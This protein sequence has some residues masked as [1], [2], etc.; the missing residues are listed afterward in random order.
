MLGK[1]RGTVRKGIAAGLRAT[2]KDLEVKKEEIMFD[3]G[4]WKGVKSH[5]ADKVSGS[6]RIK[7]SEF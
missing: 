3:A 6:C 5:E 7:V 2:S 4:I 1:K